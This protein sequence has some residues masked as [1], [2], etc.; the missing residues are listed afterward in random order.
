MESQ[1]LNPSSPCSHLCPPTNLD[2]IG[3]EQLRNFVDTYY[4]GPRMVVAAAGVE[5]D[6]FVKLCEKHFA[7]IKTQQ[8]G[9]PVDA[10]AVYQGYGPCDVL[11]SRCAPTQSYGP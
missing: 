6:S 2:N 10:P 9:Q 5:H 1:D 4:V 3:R 7:G 11:H 8:R